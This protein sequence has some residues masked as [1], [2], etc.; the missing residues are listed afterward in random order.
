MT[1][2]GELLHEGAERLRTAGSE[3]P[4]LDAELLLGFAIGVERTTVIAHHDAPWAPIMRTLYRAFVERRAVGEPVAYIRGVKEFHG[5]GLRRGR[6]ALIPR[7]ETEALVDAGVAEVM[8]RLTAGSRSAGMHP[9]RVAD[10]GTGSGAIAI[11]LVVALRRRH[12]EGEVTVIATDISPDALDL[13]RENAV[14]HAVAD[15]VRFVEAD[16]LPPVVVDPFDLVLANLPYVRHDAMAGAPGRDLVRTHPGARRRR[17]RAGRHRA[18]VA[19]VARGQPGRGRP[20]VPEIGSDQGRSIVDLVTATLPGWACTVEPD[21]AGLPAHR[22]RA[23]H[24]HRWR[25]S[26]IIRTC[27]NPSPAVRPFRSA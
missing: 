6:R 10:I 13:A 8:R 11:A 1:T 14:G 27:L 23:G 25:W 15:H 26:V 3:S 7:P 5:R 17:G 19:A 21:L 22:A 16:L 2:T 9:I 12:A 24:G 4:R 20:R 18:A